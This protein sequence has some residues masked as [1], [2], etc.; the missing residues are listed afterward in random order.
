M[1]HPLACAAAL[2][3]GGNAWRR[4]QFEPLLAEVAHVSPCYP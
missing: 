2:A 3:V 1:G 4:Q